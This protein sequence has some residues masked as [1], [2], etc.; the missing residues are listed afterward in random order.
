MDRE[1][2][3]KK[4]REANLQQVMERMV[5]MQVPAANRELLPIVYD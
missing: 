4:E 3:D 1:C 5:L 2:A